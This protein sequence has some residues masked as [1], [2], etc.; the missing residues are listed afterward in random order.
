[1]IVKKF[2]MYD[3]TQS[4]AYLDIRAKQNIANMLNERFELGVF[5]GLNN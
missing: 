5:S 2:F 1:M 3:L 4:Y